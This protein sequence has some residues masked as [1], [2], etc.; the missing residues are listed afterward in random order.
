MGSCEESGE[1]SLA[2]RLVDD[3]VVR[4]AGLEEESPP[5][6]S[7]LTALKHASRDSGPT[8]SP[9]S[10]IGRWNASSPLEMLGM[11]EVSETIVRVVSPLKASLFSA[12][13]NSLSSKW[14]VIVSLSS[15]LK[16]DLQLWLHGRGVAGGRLTHV[17]IAES[18]QSPL[19]NFGGREHLHREW[20]RA[21]GASHTSSGAWSSSRP[22]TR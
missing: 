21:F 7:A 13:A 4:A 20:I 2:E 22:A 11:T 17:G 18:L 1:F 12:A 9:M 6:P 8:G 10:S 19:F 5:T 14:V 16:I 3:E 15:R